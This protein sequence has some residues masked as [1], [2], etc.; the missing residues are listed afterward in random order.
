MPELSVGSLAALGRELGLSKSYLCELA[1]EPWWPPRGADGSWSVPSCRAAL[2]ANVSGRKARRAQPA[3]LTAAPPGPPLPP[4]QAPAP[5]ASPPVAP[6]PPA[7]TSEADAALLAVLESSSDPVELA[8]AASQL[9][10]RRLARGLAL[11]TPDARAF[12]DLKAQLEEWRRTAADL[13]ELRQ[14]EGNLIPRDVA[15]AC[16]GALARRVVNMLDSLGMRLVDQIEVWLVDEQFTGGQ[17]PE[18]ART[19]RR[20]AAEVTRAAR[21]SEC[22]DRAREEIEDMIRRE[23]EDQR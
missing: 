8:E 13:L 14:A 10:A 7:P 4:A 19:I 3:P 11:G 5:A 17:Q 16:M 12:G 21:L 2:A 20:W 23:L 22:S 15:K 1:R 18:R 9:A 6:A